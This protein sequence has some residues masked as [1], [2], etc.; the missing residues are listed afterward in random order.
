LSTALHGKLPSFT[1]IYANHLPKNE[2]S[3][4]L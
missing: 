3:Q 4:K 2:S 1:V